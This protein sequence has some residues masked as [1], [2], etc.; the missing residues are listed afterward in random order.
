MSLPYL[1][2]WEL[3]EDE[4]TPTGGGATQSVYNIPPRPS[5]YGPSAILPYEDVIDVVRSPEFQAEPWNYQTALTGYVSA[6]D[7][8]ALRPPPLLGGYTQRRRGGGGGPAPVT[9]SEAPIHIPGAPPWWKA[10]IPSQMTPESEF[11]TLTNLFLPLLSPEDQRTIATSLYQIDPET[12]AHLDPVILNIPA[13]STITQDLQTRFS[14]ARRA[15]VAMGALEQF[16]SEVGKG[17]TDLGPGATFLRNLADVARDFGG[18]GTE[19]MTRTQRRQAAAAFDPMLAQTKAPELAAFAPIAKAFA[20][21]FFS[22]G[23]IMP[24]PNLALY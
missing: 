23:P 15:D 6:A 16:A 4:P 22:A 10:L 19:R 21:P 24:G 8:A 9:Y 13:P 2:P 18:R 14:S 20:T 3:E 1:P 11:L 12:F 7:L 17:L 5:Q